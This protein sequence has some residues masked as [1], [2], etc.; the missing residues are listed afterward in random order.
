MKKGIFMNGSA[1]SFVERSLQI[2][3]GDGAL[4]DKNIVAR[5]EH[6]VQFDDAAFFDAIEAKRK[7]EDL[8]WREVGRK[9]NLSPSTFSRLARGRRPDVDTFFRLLAWLNRPAEQ[10]V[11]GLPAQQSPDTLS[12]IRAILRADSAIPADGVDALEQVVR[13]VYRR[14]KIKPRE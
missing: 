6:M 5:L 10:F 4:Q 13:V 8:S 11:K 7:S 2:S 1:A 14:L 3:I 12:S 9:L